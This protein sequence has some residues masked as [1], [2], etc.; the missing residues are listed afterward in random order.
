[1]IGPTYYFFNVN[2]THNDENVAISAEFIPDRILIDTYKVKVRR[3]RVILNEFSFFGD[4]SRKDAELYGH[5]ALN[6]SRSQPLPDFS[7]IPGGEKIGKADAF[8]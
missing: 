4:P 2:L 3:G 8:K 5:L 1:M 7:G 6:F